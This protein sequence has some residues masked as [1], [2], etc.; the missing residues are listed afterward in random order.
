MRA[1]LS[2]ALA[3]YLFK[4]LDGGMGCWRLFTLRSV[5]FG[6]HTSGLGAIA[7]DFFPSRL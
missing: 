6:V 2:F 4:G 5:S 1:F 3:Q 7:H